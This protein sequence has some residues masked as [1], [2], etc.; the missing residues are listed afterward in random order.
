MIFFR[1]YLISDILAGIVK[2]VIKSIYKVL[3]LFNLR[4]IGLLALIG[5]VL[6]FGGFFDKYESVKI[7]FYVTVAVA[8]VINIISRVNKFVQKSNEKKSKKG[9]QIVNQANI[10]NQDSDIN[11]DKSR[12]SRNN[13]A[14]ASFSGDG[15]YTGNAES[16]NQNSDFYYRQNRQNYVS[17]QQT[18]G[19]EYVSAH[20]EEKPE[21]PKYYKVRNSNCIMAEFEDRYELYQRSVNGLIKLRTDYKK[22]S[23]D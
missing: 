18:D 3:K 1:N 4:L 21:F 20:T 7:G 17:R 13:F 11:T 9:V 23:N 10:R 19:Y 16:D 14:K 2:F 15:D 6:Y 12:L 8:V 22:V 5:A